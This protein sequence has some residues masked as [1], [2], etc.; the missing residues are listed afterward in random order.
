ML[1]AFVGQSVAYASMSCE[2]LSDSHQ[3]HMSME[4]Q[5]MD[6][7]SDMAHSEMAA[8]TDDCCGV[9]CI[10]P[11]NACS[12]ATALNSSLHSVIAIRHSEPVNIYKSEQP[13]TIAKS[14]FRPP[15]FV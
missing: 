3:S 13:N 15:I 8:N 7:H 6:H 1:I 10:C 5:S 4:F 2:M 12:S 14:L 9:D 11:A